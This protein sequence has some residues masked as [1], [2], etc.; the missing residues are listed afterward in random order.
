MLRVYKPSHEWTHTIAKIH[1]GYHYD[2]TIPSRAYPPV[3]Q[4]PQNAAN[5]ASIRMILA[6]RRHVAVDESKEV[7]VI[8]IRFGD[9]KRVQQQFNTDQT[10][11]DLFKFIQDSTG[12]DTFKVT[13][14]FPPKPVIDRSQTLKEAGLMKEMVS[15]KN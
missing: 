8:Q 1:F 12:T 14:G 6:P 7:T 4:A 3:I 10:V 15:V 2:G 13:V 11:G 9:G 5:V